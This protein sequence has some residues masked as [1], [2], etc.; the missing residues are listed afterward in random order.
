[1]RVYEELFIIKPDTPEEEVDAFIGQ[2]KDLIVQGQ[3]TVEKAERWGTGVRKLAYP[4][5]R[6]KE[7]LYILVQFSSP[8]ELVK[9][10]ERRLRNADM[11][12]KFITVRVDER[13]KKVEKRKKARAKRAARK[14]QPVAAPAAPAPSEPG[15]T[16]GLPGMPAEP[17][18]TKVE[19]VEAKPEPV[20]H[21]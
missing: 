5:Q 21:E 7:G 13:L 11:V 4:V 20:A 2:V 3:G 15:P 9:E 17:I 1:M 10:V 18:Q 19:P 16:P 14:P 8:A 12:I 6:Y